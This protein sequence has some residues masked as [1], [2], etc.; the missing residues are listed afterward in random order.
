MG[1]AENHTKHSENHTKN[2]EGHT[3]KKSTLP[4]WNWWKNVWMKIFLGGIN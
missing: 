4:Q 2:G 1:V 3:I